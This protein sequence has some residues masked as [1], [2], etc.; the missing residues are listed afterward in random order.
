MKT[1]TKILTVPLL[2]LTILAAIPAAIHPVRAQPGVV[3]IA[4]PSTTDCSGAPTSFTAATGQSQVTVAVNIDSSDR[5]N[6]ID[7]QIQTDPFALR[8]LSNDLTGSILPAGLVLENSDNSVSGIARVARVAFST[9]NAPATGRLFKV[10]YQIVG[11][12]FFGAGVG[13][14]QGCDNTSVP[15]ACV[16]I[17]YGSTPQAESTVDGRITGAPDFVI[18]SSRSTTAT[19]ATGTIISA[20]SVNGFQGTVTLSTTFTPNVANGPTV[21]YNT[22]SLVLQPFFTNAS[23]LNFLV[24]D[25]T[26]VQTYTAMVT[27]T[28]GSV[29]HSVSVTVLF[30][31]L[32]VVTFFTLAGFNPIP[33][34]I[35]TDQNGN[36]KADVVIANMNVTSTNP[37]EIDAWVNATNTGTLRV[38][39][40]QLTETL[41]FN[42]FDDPP[43]NQSQSIH[44]YFVFPNQ[45]FVDITPKKGDPN[46]TVSNTNPQVVTL[47]FPALTAT[48]VKG[49][50][51]IGDRIITQVKLQ[52]A[53]K[54]THQHAGIYPITGV[55]SAVVLAFATFQNFASLN[56]PSTPLISYAKVVG[57]VNGDL[58]ID[59]VDIAIV[60]Y[61]YGSKKNGA[62]WNPAADQN[63]DGV[64]DITDIAIVAFY[65][66]QNDA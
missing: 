10:T 62:L 14:T 12:T 39:T 56:T 4:D 16:T 55:D 63:G 32:S 15:G 42:W 30:H 44:V 5:F 54:G 60:A 20:Q 27:G 24:T 41:P 3:C 43:L 6:G 34:R 51:N 17:A 38:G 22:T 50:M 53:L 36:P 23:Q 31:R 40:F 47:T 28:S 37:G 2:L 59:I 45:T 58:K 25:L 18:S 26:P 35:P 65:Y 13:F 64:I 52:Y 29:S 7:I 19:G 1:S 49:F 66:G 61:A 9:V 57:D 46:L 21:T 33:A 8:P 11:N 48:P